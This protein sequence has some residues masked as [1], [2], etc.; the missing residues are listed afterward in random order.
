M[1][2]VALPALFASLLSVQTVR[3]AQ[4]AVAADGKPYTNPVKS[5]KG[6]DPWVEYCN[7]VTRAPH[8]TTA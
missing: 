6:A 3:T 4:P 1:P 5:Q 7:R 2:A 8:L